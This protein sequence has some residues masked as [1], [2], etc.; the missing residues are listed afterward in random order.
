MS[1]H[2]L[3][4]AVAAAGSQSALAKAIGKSQGHVSKW[5][6]R[7]YVPAA[8]VIAI[9]RVTGVPRHELR[10]DLYP[11][12]DEFH[13]AKTK[14]VGNTRSSIF[15]CMKGVVT[16]PADFNPAEPFWELHDDFKN[17]DDAIVGEMD[18][19]K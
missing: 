17:H 13:S 16:L 18:K 8:S 14:I 15:G 11:R 9:E 5:L 1:I 7:R 19:S 3:E 12:E 4:K 10:P 6:E 2:P